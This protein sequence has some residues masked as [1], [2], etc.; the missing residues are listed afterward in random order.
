MTGHQPNPGMGV[1]GRGEPSPYISI[2]DITKACGSASTRVVDPYDTKA[3]IEAFQAAKDEKGVRV[4]IPKRECAL[5]VT[6]ELKAQGVSEIDQEACK[7]CYVCLNQY[8]CPA[9]YKDGKDVHIDPTACA[10]CHV[11]IQVCPF[12]AIHVKG[13]QQ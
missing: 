10:G 11:C 9:F 6:K 2:E 8:A 3:T 1:N 4:I 5:I 12:N 7:R 13:V